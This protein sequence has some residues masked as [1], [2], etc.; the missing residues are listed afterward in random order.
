[1]SKI[2]KFRNLKNE[3]IKFEIFKK[4]NYRFY[5]LILIF[6][7]SFKIFANSQDLSQLKKANELYKLEKYENAIEVYNEIIKSN[8]NN[9]ELFYNL[10]NCYFRLDEIGKSI[11]YYEKALK[12]NPSDEDI[13]FNLK[14]ANLKTIDKF[15]TKEQLEI[16]TFYENFISIFHSN[17]WLYF[18]VFMLTIVFN[19]FINF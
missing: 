4:D 9:P 19:L 11:L 15:N 7:F 8:N 12:L 1:M 2:L 18:S 5:K 13:K 16:V 6:I 3:K 17:T 10:G 14:I